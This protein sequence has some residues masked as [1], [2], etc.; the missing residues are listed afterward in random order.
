MVSV[1]TRRTRSADDA[2]STFNP[3]HMQIHSVYERRR[4]LELD[5]EDIYRTIEGQ[6]DEK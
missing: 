6:E 2:V 4:E 1:T 3:V 5:L